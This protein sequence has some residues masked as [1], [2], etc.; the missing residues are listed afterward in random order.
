[1]SMRTRTMEKRLPFAVALFGAV[2]GFVVLR[3]CQWEFNPR[4]AQFLL[5]T[6]TFGSIM[7]GF[8]AT[9]LSLVVSLKSDIMERIKQSPYYRLLIDY[10]RAALYLAIW[11]ALYGLGG[12][13][14][15][16][17]IP[18]T[19]AYAHLLGAIWLGLVCWT[20]SCFFRAVSISVVIFKKAE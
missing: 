8:V 1:M 18:R 5:A 17:W 7:A 4:K 12:L 10:L 9:N 14:F 2:A 3:Y 19:G 20:A 6:V 13:F 16:E 15:I 11:L